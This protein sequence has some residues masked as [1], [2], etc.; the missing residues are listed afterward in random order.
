MDKFA[1]ACRLSFM[2]W[3]SSLPGLDELPEPNY[4]K[5]HIKRMNKLFDKMRGESYHRFTRKTVR[6]MVVAAVIF[7]LTLCA[8]VIPSSREYL[9]NDFDIFGMYKISEHNKNS[10]TG[11]IQAGYIPEGYK[12]VSTE[13]LNKLIAN[14]YENDDGQIFYISKQSS[15]TKIEFDI[16]SGTIEKIVDDNI[17]Y[18]YYTSTCGFYGIIWTE[19][20]YIY[21]VD[22]QLSKDELIKIA[23]NIN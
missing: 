23:E 1:E 8:F 22:G 9:I 12:L 3:D 16:E 18:T 20:D 4:S 13:K 21:Q 11:E 17:E 10:V 19:N 7:A 5:A 6:V 15:S 2:D 14:Y